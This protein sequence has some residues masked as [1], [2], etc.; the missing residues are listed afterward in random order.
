MTARVAGMAL[1]EE[2]ARA[3]R[4]AFSDPA[5]SAARALELVY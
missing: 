5:C 1:A 4:E 3:L 2:L